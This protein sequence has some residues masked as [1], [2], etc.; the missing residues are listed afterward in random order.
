MPAEAGQFDVWSLTAMSTM[1]REMHASGKSF[2]V[3]PVMN[4]ISS[5]ERSTLTSGLEMEFEKLKDAFGAEPHRIVKRNAFSW[6]AAE[7]KG[8]MEMKR[9]RDTEKA[10]DEL[11]GLYERVFA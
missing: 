3:V 7:G 9:N 1:I 4:K 8:V 2:K 6:A 5:D 11:R 10:Q